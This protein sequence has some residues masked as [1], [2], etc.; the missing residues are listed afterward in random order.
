MAST[1]CID[2]QVGS[3]FPALMEDSVEQD[4]GDWAFEPCVAIGARVHWHSC[5]SCQA[6]YPNAIETIENLRP[7]IEAMVRKTLLK[8]RTETLAAMNSCS[9]ATNELR[10]CFAQKLA[11]L[12]AS[13]ED[14]Q[15]ALF[16]ISEDM[17]DF[18]VRTDSYDESSQRV[19]LSKYSGFITTLDIQLP[20]LHL[21][22]DSLQRDILA[23]SQEILSHDVT[24]A[25][26]SRPRR[27]FE[28]PQGAK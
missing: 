2:P 5:P 24:A 3:W 8:K 28:Y 26:C 18:T 20:D 7:A 12:E 21:R 19:P 14:V 1:E 22:V 27:S 25:F 9:I 11:V 17:S 15:W 23:P 10:D 6:E 4:V 13:A 16:Y